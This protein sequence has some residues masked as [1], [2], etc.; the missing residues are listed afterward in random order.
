MASLTE[1]A[2]QT[3][4]IDFGLE[5]YGYVKVTSVGDGGGDDVHRPEG[6]SDDHGDSSDDVTGNQWINMSPGCNEMQSMPRS[7]SQS[8]A[9]SIHTSDAVSPATTKALSAHWEYMDSPSPPRGNPIRPESPMS[10]WTTVSEAMRALQTPVR[11]RTTADSELDDSPPGAPQK[12]KL[13]L[14]R[15]PHSPVDDIGTPDK[16]SPVSP[17]PLPDWDSLDLDH[18]EPSEDAQKNAPEGWLSEW[19]F[20]NEKQRQWVIDHPDGIF[21]CVVSDGR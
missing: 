9:P 20:M 5:S 3:Q 10:P 21:P 8:P 14:T 15:F 12:S 7:M 4:T 17:M 16:V 2:T 6:S 11:K 18:H 13:K 1:K 19:D